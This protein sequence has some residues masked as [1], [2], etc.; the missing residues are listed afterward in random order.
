MKNID[1]MPLNNWSKLFIGQGFQ[2]PLEKFLRIVKQ[3][4]PR[5]F[6]S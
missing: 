2:F 6:I 5:E 3:D 1:V 4:E